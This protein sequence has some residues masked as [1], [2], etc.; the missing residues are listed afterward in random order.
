[1][2]QPL[3]DND[4]ERE[5]CVILWGGGEVCIQLLDYYPALKNEKFVIVD[6]SKSRQGYSLC[7]KQI[8]GPEFIDKNNV[9]TVILTVVRRKSEIMRQL[10]AYPSIANIYLPAARKISED[11]AQFV[12]DPLHNGTA[13]VL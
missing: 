7:E 13:A 5:E 10:G 6:S 8:F 12:L 4:F 9:K 11:C 1:L 3:P 2:H